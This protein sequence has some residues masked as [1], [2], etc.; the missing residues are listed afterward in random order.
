M[1]ESNEY[2]FIIIPANYYPLYDWK[3][4]GEGLLYDETQKDMDEAA[5]KAFQVQFS[6]YHWDTHI[7]W[8]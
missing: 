8:N 3:A 1:T 5:K 6:G 2:V 4:N 7:V